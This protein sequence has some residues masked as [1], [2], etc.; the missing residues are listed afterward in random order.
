M[1]NLEIKPAFRHIGGGL[2]HAVHRNGEH[3]GSI[4]EVF[5]DVFYV[6]RRAGSA[7]DH[8][9]YRRFDDAKQS[10]VE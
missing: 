7:E 5:S 8:K 4:K 3:I 1:N 9:R 2:V 6:S 10:F